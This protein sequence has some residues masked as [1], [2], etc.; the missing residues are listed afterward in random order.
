MIS[1]VKIG[2][3][4]EIQLQLKWRHTTLRSRL[5]RIAAV[6]PELEG[7]VLPKKTNKDDLHNAVYP[8]LRD[9]HAWP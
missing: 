9:R 3:K 5:S 4:K 6:H 1:C 8:Y 2:R 7:N